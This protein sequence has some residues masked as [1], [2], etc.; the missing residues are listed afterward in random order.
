MTAK[1]NPIGLGQVTDSQAM[2]RRIVAEHDLP[3]IRAAS[4]RWH[5][6]VK[7]KIKARTNEAIAKM[8]GKYS[9][10]SDNEKNKQS[11]KRIASDTY[12][13]VTS[14]A[15]FPIPSHIEDEME[16]SEDVFE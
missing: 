2:T 7:E 12:K 3:L 15:F 4:I 13:V 8:D 9:K 10:D 1:G 14:R 6:D 5:N 11:A 16:K